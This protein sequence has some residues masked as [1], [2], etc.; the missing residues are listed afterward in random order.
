MGGSR[1]GKWIES[2]AEMNDNSPHTGRELDVGMR[3]LEE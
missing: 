2:G 1:D 3:L